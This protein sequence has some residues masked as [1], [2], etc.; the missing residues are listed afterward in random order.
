MKIYIAHA[1]SFDFLSQ[2]YEP[3]AMSAIT[4]HHELIFPHKN[5][6]SFMHSKEIIKACDLVVAEVSYP[7]TGLGI[8]LG[9]ADA[10]NTPILCIHH[11]KAKPSRSLSAITQHIITYDSSEGMVQEVSHFIDEY[12]EI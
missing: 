4:Q 7:A 10:F 6:D 5:K 2:L 8:E 1:V 12:R 3:L 11:N 9:W